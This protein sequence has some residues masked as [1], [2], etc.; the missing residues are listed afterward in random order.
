MNIQRLLTTTA[1]LMLFIGTASAQQEEKG[2]LKSW[3]F[4]EVQGGAQLTTTQY[5]KDKLVTPTG[6]FS[7]DII[8][9]LPSVC[10]SMLM[11]ERPRPVLRITGEPMLGNMSQPTLT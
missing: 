7:I 1:I 9:H 8:S 10:V 6:A 4:I 3:T 2:K 11:E 5:R